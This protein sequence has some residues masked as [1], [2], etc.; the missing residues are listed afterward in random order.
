MLAGKFFNATG[1]AHDA[2][3]KETSILAAQVGPVTTHYLWVIEK[4]VNGSDDYIAK[5]T[6]Q[7]VHIFPCHSNLFYSFN[8]DLQPRQLFEC[9][10]WDCSE[11]HLM[12]MEMSDMRDCPSKVSA[13][14]D[15]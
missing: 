10:F 6:K 13:D 1:A 9:G 15:M 8:T 12:E 7:H 2:I 4:F 14:D 11:G 5:E 3:Y